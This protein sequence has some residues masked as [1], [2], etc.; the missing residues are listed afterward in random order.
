[1]RQFSDL[2]QD[3][4]SRRFQRCPPS[5]HEMALT[6]H[7]AQASAR[8]PRPSRPTPPS[9]VSSAQVS[10]YQQRG[11]TMPPDPPA[12]L[13]SHP[14]HRSMVH[15]SMGGECTRARSSDHSC[16]SL[17]PTP[18]SFGA[19]TPTYSPH[20]H[21][22]MGGGE[23]PDGS[24][25]YAVG[26]GDSIQSP[27]G[28]R[29]M[30]C[31]RM[32]G[33]RLRGRTRDP[34]VLG[35][36]RDSP[37]AVT[38]LG[39]ERWPSTLFAPL[40]KRAAPCECSDGG[41]AR[42]MGA[43]LPRCDVHLSLPP[44][45]SQGGENGSDGTHTCHTSTGVKPIDE[46]GATSYY[47][48]SFDEDCISTTNAVFV[49]SLSSNSTKGGSKPGRASSRHRPSVLEAAHLA[50]SLVRPAGSIEAEAPPSPSTVPWRIVL[51]Q[52]G[53][54]QSSSNPSPDRKVLRPE[55]ITPSLP[56][57]WPAATTAEEG[58]TTQTTTS[59][60][61]SK[62]SAP[63][64]RFWRGAIVYATVLLGCTNYGSI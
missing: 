12:P 6:P 43:F 56:H 52:L 58:S 23:F 47:A 49:F 2:P 44:A 5:L 8:A 20:H 17:A 10:P 19:S 61:R 18:T 9:T 39:D 54:G 25:S 29:R 42:P 30:G 46:Q 31:S 57:P 41:P 63:C 64:S 32:S 53:S 51:C 36:P 7:L 62:A 45:P 55:G 59:S 22:N 48:C 60:P 16:G 35:R 34:R 3:D 14:P 27:D 11:S 38:L 40:Y 1:M 24:D 4:G 21:V 33:G 28:H 37:R 13:A 26:R 15:R 50:S